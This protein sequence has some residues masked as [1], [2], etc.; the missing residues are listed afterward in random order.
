MTIEF[1]F[2]YPY[3]SITESDL[4]NFEKTHD[5]KLPNDYRRFLLKYNGGKNPTPEALKAKVYGSNTLTEL[6]IELFYG[7]KSVPNYARL[8]PNALKRKGLGPDGF[9]M[10]ASIGKCPYLMSLRD[11]DYGRIYYWDSDFEFCLD[12][13]NDKSVYL[14]AESFTDLIS[15][16]Y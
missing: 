16:L 2:A 11:K 12:D 14:V 3:D 6:G 1:E 10:I 5:I 8:S 13:T 4:E 9:A 7:I 15:K